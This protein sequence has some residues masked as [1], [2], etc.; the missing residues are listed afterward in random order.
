M[1]HLVRVAISLPISLALG[2]KLEDWDVDVVSETGVEKEMKKK[3]ERKWN[4][5]HEKR[6]M[7][8]E[9]KNVQSKEAPDGR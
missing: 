4:D 9:R 8:R 2:V 1:R 5:A 3:K 7:F 6:R